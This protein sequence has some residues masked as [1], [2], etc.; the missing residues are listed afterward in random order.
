M[1]E[2]SETL[3]EGDVN[4]IKFRV[5]VYPKRSKKIQIAVK[6]P[7]CGREGILNKTTLKGKK[8]MFKV[9]HSRNPMRSCCFSWTTPGYEELK[10][11]Y[12]ICYERWKKAI[13]KN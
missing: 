4:G 8:L 5:T 10:E 13:E 2:D 9:I 12:N 11:I 7:K 3:E 6:C 1:G